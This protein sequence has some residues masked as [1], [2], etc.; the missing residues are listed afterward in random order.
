MR[1][2][3]GGRWLAITLACATSLIVPA[4]AVAGPAVSED[5]W[6]A[7]LDQQVVL[8]LADGTS[9]S[10]KLVRVSKKAV[11]VVAADGAVQ[12]IEKS[13][14]A[15]LRMDVPPTEPPPADPPV[16]TPVEEPPV[17]EPPVVEAPVEEPPAEEPVEPVEEPPVEEPPPPEPT[18]I[19]VEPEPEPEPEHA[20]V[21][22]IVGNGLV[23]GAWSA[24]GVHAKT[25]AYHLELGVG[26]NFTKHIGLYALGGG[27]L[28]GRVDDDVQATL[29]RLAIA[30]AI[31]A[32]YFG[33][34]PGIGV[35]FSSLRSGGAK[36]QDLGL[37]IPIHVM[38]MI[39]LPQKL[40][41]GVGLAY[42][43]AVLKGF[44]IFVN[45][46]GVEVTL[47]RW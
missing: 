24:D 10:G 23:F 11:V 31:R 26:Y 20:R 42:D 5:A 32:K 25:L 34:I 37:A 2:W 7:M 39:P 46:I 29:G 13:K 22:F 18:P 33:F 8:E 17:E 14:V 40:Y 45:V 21:G 6:Q 47:G 12:T 43:F 44:D 27:L 15:S 41:L 28:G 38:G 19:V 4:I 1:C 35:A 9:V 16:E 30:P 3:L 36:Y